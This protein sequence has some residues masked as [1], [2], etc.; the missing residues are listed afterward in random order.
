MAK[1][2]KKTKRYVLARSEDGSARINISIPWE[3]IEEKRKEALLELGE[4]REFAGFRKGKAPLDI[5]LKSLSPELVIE[6]ALGKILPEKF[7]EAINEH[8]LKPISYPRFEILKAKDNEDWEVAAITCEAPEIDLGNYKDAIRGAVATKS[9]WTPEK[10]K[11]GEKENQELT[12]EEKEQIAIR[13]LLASIDFKIPAMLVEEEVNSRLS[14]LLSRIE[15]LGL[16]LE[17]YLASIKKTAEGL[18][19]EYTKQ[20]TETLKLEF[21]LGKV[22]ND[23]S[24]V[25]SEAEIEKFIHDSSSGDSKIEERLREPSQK[26]LIVSILTKRKVIDY[27]SNL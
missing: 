11:K 9:I 26:S 22:A 27:L 15:K 19:E 21:I 2:T 10:L 1:S 3:I 24:V 17:S 13:T 20:A 23:A 25:V 12:H 6:R 14:D 5:L 8:K 18:R 4:T 16:S 7:N